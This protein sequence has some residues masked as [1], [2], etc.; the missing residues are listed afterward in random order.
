MRARASVEWQ[1]NICIRTHARTHA[2]VSL[3][4]RTTLPCR[5]LYTVRRGPRD[6]AMMRSK[7]VP[8]CL[9]RSP[10]YRARNQDYYCYSP[11]SANGTSRT[12]SRKFNYTRCSKLA[13]F[14]RY[15]DGYL[16]NGSIFHKSISSLSGFY[17][18]ILQFIIFLEFDNFKFQQY[19]SL[20]LIM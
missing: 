10:E 11:I 19:Y 3:T 1:R 13:V 6:R 9:F 20:I 16:K 12:D 8:R 7:T 17:F 4:G 18:E 14:F 5:C 15:Q 2:S